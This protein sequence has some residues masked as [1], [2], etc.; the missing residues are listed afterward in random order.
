MTDLTGKLALV[1]GASRGLGYEVAKA[2][3]AKGAH[4]VAVARTVGGLEELDDAI[5]A[6]AEESGNGETTL[7]P[8][9]IKDDPG[10][11]RLGAAIFQRWAGLDIF[12]HCAAHATP[13]GPTEHVSDKDLDA[14]IAVNF[15][16]VQRLIRVIDPLLKQRE[17]AQAVFITAPDESG[18]KF[19]SA[20]G[21]AKSAGEAVARSYAAENARK[22]PRVWLAAPPPM[23][24][25]VRGR[26]Y[27]GEDQ[28]TLT[29]C[30]EP[31]AALA[32][33]IIAGGGEPGETVRL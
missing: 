24:T 13:M 11:E 1:T 33:K 31:A 10:L 7:V 17:K 16:A 12:V 8:F 9:D 23:P 30:A 22:G 19:Q 27:P 5:K 20:Y 6:A 21:A 14:A 25:A 28:S 32:A 26:F 3:A 4:V 2:L 29:P 15:R 18:A